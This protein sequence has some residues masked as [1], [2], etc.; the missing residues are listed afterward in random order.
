MDALTTQQAIE[1]ISTLNPDWDLSGPFSAAG[2]AA[3]DDRA[4]RAR[5]ARAE[6][7]RLARNISDHKLRRYWTKG[8]GAVKIGWGVPGDFDR[9]VAELG[10]YVRDPKGLCAE[11]H[12]EALGVWPGQEHG[13][14]SEIDDDPVG[15]LDDETAALLQAMAELDDE[16]NLGRAA[17]WDPAKHPR[18]P[19]TGHFLDIVDRLKASIRLHQA[20]G[21]GKTHP[22]DGYSRDQLMK[23]AKTRGITLKRG[24]DRDSI[25][26][27]LLADLTTRQGGNASGTFTLPK[28]GPPIITTSP[29]T[30]W[31]NNQ[32]T[33]NVQ[34]NGN[35]IGI[36]VH[37]SGG[38]YFPHGTG[39][40]PLGNVVRVNPGVGNGYQTEKAAVDALVQAN[41]PRK[42]SGPGLAGLNLTELPV[43]GR[44]GI[45]GPARRSW[46]ISENGTPIG[47]VHDFGYTI[48][49]DGP[50]GVPINNSQH[51]S[52]SAAIA[53]LV[54]A[55]PNPPGKT[56]KASGPVLP[57]GSPH[58]PEIQG[59]L[60]I[61]Y[62]RDPKGHTIARQLEVY[63]SLRR[64]HFDQL[65]PAEKQGVLADLAYIET[66]SKSG[67]N[68][69][70]ASKLIDRFTPPGTAHGQIPKQAVLPPPNVT[71]SQTR[72]AD[73]AG[74]PGL[75]S[76]LP[77][78]KTGKSGDGWTRTASGTSG[79]W[80]Q[81]GAAGLMLRHVDA[82]GEE[83]FLM[84]QRGP[85]ISDPGKWQFPGG[86]KDEKED[87]YQGATRE[88]A[89]ELGFKNNDLD[90]ARVHGTHTKEVP[91]VQVPGLH[92]GTVPWAYVSIAATV[93]RQLKPDL[94]TPEARAETSDAK[95]MTRAEID[96]LQTSGKLL[97][98]L[99]GG[100]LQQ[101]VLTLFPPTHVAPTTVGRP[102]L[103][104]V[105]PKRLT[106]TPTV[107][108]PTAKTHKPSLG[109][110]LIGD[111]SSRDK[112]RQDVT[113]ARKL[114]AGKTADDRLA[115]I[116][117][118]QGF[119]DVPTVVTKGEYDKLKA[120]G[121]YIEVYRGVK[122]AGSYT[123]PTRGSAVTR[124][125]TAAQIH[126][127]FRT[128]SAYYGT[129]IY[130]NGYYFATDRSIAVGYSDNT[131]G[132]VLRAL[133]PKSAKIAE[134]KTIERQAQAHGQRYSK[135]KGKSHEVATLWDEGRYA[136][137]RGHDMVRIPPGHSATSHNNPNYVVLNRS[138]LIVLEEQ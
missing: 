124:T 79:P 111:D 100:Q 33:I 114:Y 3:E 53:A 68:A 4:K 105:R 7:D 87:F 95:W 107:N 5:E 10:K 93:D 130:G 129:G 106:G 65:G 80:G 75:L 50:N 12:H 116:A 74:T 64:S 57:Q 48:I 26:A 136:A 135:A 39:N 35:D 52:K 29:G 126:E 28:A 98:P 127:E 90:N 37:A 108:A 94:S 85:G 121:D 51:T 15:E 59:A 81:Y 122:G 27:K 47:T 34:V 92:G 56:T 11:Y 89:E 55:M 72:V 2:P 25:A 137:A 123:G 58:G 45:F 46:E 40:T 77:H 83:R 109:R 41:M 134:H 133:V 71:A 8:E 24:E 103:V 70:K 60:D 43:H 54:A 91:G 44:R 138:V 6:M 102:G 96:K 118:M 117:A 14:R 19:A 99:A 16:A 32:T 18:D 22:F 38:G 69:T 42:V 110:D 84:I 23:A 1:R 113:K 131:K 73:P 36:V 88:V 17:V 63:G 30:P 9:C 97:A 128:G 76:R 112:L 67:P 20:G 120:S 125:K 132:S 104:H 66:T 31:P 115:A 101:N 13:R 61:L 86:A 49:A 82:N 21:T 78:G 62:G 119:D